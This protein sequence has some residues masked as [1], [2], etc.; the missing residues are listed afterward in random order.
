MRNPQR[1]EDSSLTVNVTTQTGI[2]V[3]L[4][5]RGNNI[6]TTQIKEND[7]LNSLN[8]LKEKAIRSKSPLYMTNY[9]IAVASK[10]EDKLRHQKCDSR[11]SPQVWATISHLLIL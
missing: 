2:Y 8:L 11:D 10:W 4:I 6:E 1:K 3:N 9:V 5:R 7:Y